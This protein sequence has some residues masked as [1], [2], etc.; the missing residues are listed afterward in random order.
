M[1]PLLLLLLLAPVG[2][3]AHSGSEPDRLRRGMC[4]VGGGG[5][6]AGFRGDSDA[7]DN[8]AVDDGRWDYVIPCAQ[9]GL[10]FIP[11]HDDS[12]LLGSRQLSS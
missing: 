12:N 8:D 4:G 11:C 2:A 1:L 5:Q 9:S 3:V 7:D 6:S 10:C